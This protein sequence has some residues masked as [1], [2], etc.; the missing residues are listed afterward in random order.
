MSVFKA[1]KTRGIRH[2]TLLLARLIAGCF[3]CMQSLSVREKRPYCINIKY[4]S[5]FLTITHQ[6]A[7][8]ITCVFHGKVERRRYVIWGDPT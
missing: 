1:C 8:S 3:F 2:K 7:R 4:P 5:S 6:E